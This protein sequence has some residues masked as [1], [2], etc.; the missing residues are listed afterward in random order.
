[1]PLT[2]RQLLEPGFELRGPGCPLRYVV[3]MSDDL[4]TRFELRFELGGRLF[5][6]DTPPTWGQWSDVL[7]VARVGDHALGG[8]LREGLD[9]ESGPTSVWDFGQYRSDAGTSEDVYRQLQRGFLE[10]ELQGVR[11]N[12]RFR[13]AGGGE[14]WR[15][16]RLSGPAVSSVSRSV[17]SGRDLAEIR[18]PLST[19]R[20]QFRIWLEWEQYYADPLPTP[21]VVVEDGL[22]VDLNFSARARGVAVGM[23]LQHVLPLVPQCEVKELPVDPKRQAE[24]LDRLV[25]Y[26]DYIQ[27]FSPHSAAVDLSAHPDPA[28]IA[29]RIVAKL[30]ARP[31]GH[32]RYGTGPSVWVAQLAARQQN[33]YGYA[34]DVAAA[35]A[36]QH[37]DNLLVASL[38]QREKLRELGVE[39]IGAVASMNP[40]WLRAQF[41]EGAHTLVTAAQGKTRDQ[42]DALY[43]PQATAQSVG[44]DAPVNDS[45]VLHGAVDQLARQ[46]ATKIVGR[47]AGLVVLTAEQEDGHE[48]TLSR[49]YNR[50]VH[51]AD[52]IQASLAYLAG[53]LQKQCPDIVRL[54]AR[55]DQLEPLKTSQQELYVAAVRTDTQAALASVRSSLGGQSI[56]LASQIE[57]PRR[58]QVL[59]AWRHATG[60]N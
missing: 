58:E 5:S 50:P 40:V 56:V 60:W 31:L 29:A 22:V 25:P 4:L 16:Q 8:L 9:P 3:R 17:L 59:R 15:V 18:R 1:M 27:P 7:D 41:G 37:V 13:I 19:R 44:F 53:E 28:D 42:V 24:W 48:Q 38:E 14:R 10:V 35:L 26:S 32:L 46:L 47:Q 45:L 20:R 2:G 33:P 57:A 21:Q 23:R 43:P 36:H 30:F 6:L 11:L 49:A 51:T 52:R 39:T 55:L 54:T 34:R 12:G